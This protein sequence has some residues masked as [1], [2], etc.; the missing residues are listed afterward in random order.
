M[1][2][3]TSWCSHHKKHFSYEVFCDRI[4]KN[5]AA[6]HDFTHLAYQWKK[7]MVTQV[8]LVQQKRLMTKL[9]V[10][11]FINRHQTTKR[12]P[13]KLLPCFPGLLPYNDVECIL[14]LFSMS[15]AYV[16]PT[17]LL[18]SDLLNKPQPQ[19]LSP[20]DVKQNLKGYHPALTVTRSC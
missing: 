17:V 2:E 19:I 4:D 13:D 12:T 15:I 16:Q 14:L 7:N 6:A 11:F 20:G 5:N 9:Q 10:D 18:L 1:A 3:T 8:I